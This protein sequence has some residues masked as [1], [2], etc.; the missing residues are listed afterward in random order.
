LRLA[1][2]LKHYKQET[3]EF[4]LAGSS[5]LL[6][7]PFLYF[8]VLKLVAR[9]ENLSFTNS[10]LATKEDKNKNKHEN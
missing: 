3:T 1:E 8:H 10:L 7:A 9:D 6:D 5:Q 4:S 2:L